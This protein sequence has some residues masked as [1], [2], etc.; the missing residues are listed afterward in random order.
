MND[1]QKTTITI[2]EVK[3]VFHYTAKNGVSYVD[4]KYFNNKIYN[5]NKQVNLEKYKTEDIY[6]ITI[7]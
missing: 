6:L 2:S 4:I 3:R 7:E 1:T 5:G